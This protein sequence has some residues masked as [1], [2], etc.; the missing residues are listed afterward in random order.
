MSLSSRR[1]DR[2]DGGNVFTK[3]RVGADGGSASFVPVDSELLLLKE[4]E[5]GGVDAPELRRRR[6]RSLSKTAC[7]WP[8]LKTRTTSEDKAITV[9]NATSRGSSSKVEKL[10]ADMFKPRIYRALNPESREGRTGFSE[11]VSSQG[12]T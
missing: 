8:L 9:A 5:R 3:S 12:S 4:N 2:L 1:A 10:I 6:I 7:L 11:S